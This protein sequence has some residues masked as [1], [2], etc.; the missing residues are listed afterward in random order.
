MWGYI[1]TID[2]IKVPNTNKISIAASIL[3]FKPNCIGLNIRLNIIFNKNGNATKNEIFELKYNCA[4][5]PKLTAIKIYNTDHT[6]P[7]IHDGGAHVG[8]INCEYQVVS[9]I[10]LV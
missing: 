8:F 6:G 5:L 3:F 10:S 1:A 7:K 2:H 9:F 4:T